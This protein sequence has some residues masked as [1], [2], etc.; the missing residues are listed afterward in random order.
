M[1]FGSISSAILYLLGFI[2]AIIASYSRSKKLQKISI[3][4][5]LIGY[6]FHTI[7]IGNMIW[8]SS[9]LSNG[10]FYFSLFSWILLLVYFLLILRYRIQFLSL[11][12]APL[13]FIFLVSSIVIGKRIVP[14]PKQMSSLWFGFHIVSLFISIALICIGFGGAIMY[15]YVNKK[16]KDK[17]GLNSLK[18]QTYSLEMLDR[19]NHWVV[20][21]AFPLFTLG[22]LSGFIWARISWHRIFSWDV[23]EIWSLIIWFIFAYLFHQRMAIG[24]KGKKPAIIIIWIFVLTVLSFTIINLFFPTHH[25]FRP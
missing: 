18:K 24:W 10:H 19:I 17:T 3:T 12:V 7:V 20:L 14:F 4:I 15:L 21:C 2:L 6:I 25:S 5:V 13:A 11:T 23:K 22:I 1:L 9:F 16:I 8:K